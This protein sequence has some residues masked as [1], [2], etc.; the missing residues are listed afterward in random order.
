MQSYIQ[1]LTELGYTEVI[2]LLLSFRFMP[3]YFLRCV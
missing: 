2:L 1:K 3:I